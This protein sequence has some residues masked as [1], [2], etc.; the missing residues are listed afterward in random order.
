M[1]AS[2]SVKAAETA[3]LDDREVPATTT[4]SRL[5]T[6]RNAAVSGSTR[7]SARLRPEEQCHV[8]TAT[9]P[10]RWVSGRECEGV[11]ENRGRRASATRDAQAR[12]NCD[13]R[14]MYGQGRNVWDCLPP[15]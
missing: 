14:A 2:V 1:V 12:P 8:P 13:K 15:T 6:R 10:L 7:V 9:R 4:A 11:V 3:E 5:L